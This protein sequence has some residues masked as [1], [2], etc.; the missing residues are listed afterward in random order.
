MQFAFYVFLSNCVSI[1]ATKTT[2]ALQETNVLMKEEIR[3][4]YSNFEVLQTVRSSC[5]QPWQVPIFLT[6]QLKGLQTS[7]HRALPMCGDVDHI[8][9]VVYSP[10]IRLT[11]RSTLTPS[12]VISASLPPLLPPINSTPMLPWTR[13]IVELPRPYR[14]STCSS[15]ISSIKSAQV[16]KLCQQRKLK[17]S[18]PFIKVLEHEVPGRVTNSLRRLFSHFFSHVFLVHFFLNDYV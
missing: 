2:I 8:L 15:V 18:P 13:L 9:Q 16:S 7:H 10:T 11:H 1:F 5:T 12:T 17:Q 4:K 3:T 6:L 14:M